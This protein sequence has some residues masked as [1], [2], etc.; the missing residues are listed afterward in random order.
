M[1]AQVFNCEMEAEK[2]EAQSFLCRNLKLDACIIHSCCMPTH[3]LINLMPLT[4]KACCKLLSEGTVSILSSDSRHSCS[5]LISDI[6]TQPSCP[7]AAEVLLWE[8]WCW[9]TLVISECVWG[10]EC[11]GSC[12]M[13]AWS[14]VWLG[15]SS[16]YNLSFTHTQRAC[17]FTSH[18]W[19]HPRSDGVL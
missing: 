18:N 13:N 8:V 6:I 15:D 7:S 5:L 4:D 1:H 17:F 14:P 11:G 9:W 10:Q 2:V 12:R 19:S 16:C 3:L